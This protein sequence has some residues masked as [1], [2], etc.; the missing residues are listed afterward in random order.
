MCIYYVGPPSETLT[1]KAPA[2]LEPRHLAERHLTV[3]YI[4]G[5]KSINTALLNSERCYF[6]QFAYC[7]RYY[8][9][10]QKSLT[11]QLNI[12]PGLKNSRNYYVP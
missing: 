7:Y 10:Q 5:Q 11:M 2:E 3:L 9:T 1:H 4:T 6:C 12:E 8:V